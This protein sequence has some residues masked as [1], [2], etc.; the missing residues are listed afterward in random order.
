MA[1]MNTI[2]VLEPAGE[3]HKLDALKL[4]PV[5]PLKGLRLAILDNAKPNFQRLALL[6]GERLCAEQGLGSVK[7]YRK[8]NPAVGAGVELL[9]EI[10]RSADLAFTGSAD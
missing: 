4:N 5:A 9:D 8:E 7:H 2:E 6:A 1:S 3:V 10:A